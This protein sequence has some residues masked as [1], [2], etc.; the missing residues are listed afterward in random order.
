MAALYYAAGVAIAGWMWPRWWWREGVIP[1]AAA[2]AAI[3]RSNAISIPALLSGTALQAA[4]WVGPLLLLA[5]VFI[6]ARRRLPAVSLAAAAAAAAVLVSPHALYYDGGLAI[7]GLLV[8]AARYPSLR[9]VAV[10]TWALAWLQP[11]SAVSPIPPLTVVCVVSTVLV[12]RNA[13]S[14]ETSGPAAVDLDRSTR[15]VRR[16]R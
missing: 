3:D 10:A 4:S 2:D 15:D 16:G 9:A 6:A 5:L 14:D 11:F 7:L 13:P 12:L 8:V 1:F